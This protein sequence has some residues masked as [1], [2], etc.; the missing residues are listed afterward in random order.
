MLRVAASKVPPLALR[1]REGDRNFQ[2]GAHLLRGVG[3]RYYTG[4]KL[5]ELRV[6]PSVHDGITLG[7]D[8]H[9]FDIVDH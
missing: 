5:K 6:G 3:K 2:D 1:L 8:T 4:G 9:E 7:V